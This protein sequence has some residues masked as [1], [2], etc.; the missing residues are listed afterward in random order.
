VPES[1][2]GYL[3]WQ[4]P[5]S[6]N[7]RREPV[8]SVET[9]MPLP[10]VHLSVAVYL[11]EKDGGF[12]SPDFLLGS[13]AP[14]AIHMRPN[15]GKRDK[16]HVHLVDLDVPNQ[17]LVGVFQN[18]YVLEG[19]QLMGF[20]KGYLTHILTDRIWWQS[21]FNPFRNE[22][23]PIL[24]DQELRSLYYRETDQ[25]DLDLFRQVPWRPEVW[26]RL[27]AATAVDFA[28]FLTAEEI[29]Q[30]RDRTLVW[31]EDPGHD[32][33]VEPVHITRANTQA[34]ISQAVQEIA[35]IFADLKW[36]LGSKG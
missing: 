13:I 6:L 26:S 11:S 34:F 35:G 17:E 20:P 21:V 2:S 5:L 25:I 31:Y 19:S 22:L 24:S 7:S 16:E 10:M 9:I 8:Y 18:K 3:F 33:K 27:D 30:W 23:H 28:P 32:P 1:L 12:P 15:T 29:I 36:P 4:T 14:D